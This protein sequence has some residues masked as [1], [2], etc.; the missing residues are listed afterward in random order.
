MAHRVSV[1]PGDGVGPEVV[2][3]AQAVLE[4]TGVDIEWDEHHLGYLSTAGEGPL[5][6][7]TLA[8]IRRNG[9]ALKGPV[10]T[11]TT[12][13]PSANVALRRALDLYV[14]VRPARSLGHRPPG[15]AGALD[16]VVVRET[17]ED[18][19][20]G[21]EVVAGT[22]EAEELR[23]WLHDRGLGDV[24]AGSAFSLKP[25]S[26]AAV[27][28]AA[29]FTLEW[30]RRNGRRKL[31]VVHKSTVMRA[32][33]GIYLDVLDELAAAHPDVVVDRCQVDAACARLV[34]E[35]EAFDVLFM[36]NMYGDIMSDIAAALAGGIGSAPGANFGDGVAV[37]EAV[38]GTAPAH[39]GRDDVNPL[40]LI[41][42]GVLLL[43]H[44]GEVEAASR[45][46]AAVADLVRSGACLTYDLLGRREGAARTSEVAAA[47]VD[48][49]SP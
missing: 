18:L 42:S 30:M 43:A 11:S 27:Q 9:V 13:G 23:G 12:G 45:L 1:V 29:A 21:I 47:L 33:D 2:R 15:A 14:Q 35:P 40:G 16:V 37:F 4:A 8:S 34:Q 32:T 25:A 19:Y 5:P 17:T 41:R 46:D 36:P 3:A 20:Q 28:R 38:H 39:A 10:A 44:L 6:E 49:L 24:A 31:T 26:A 7:A 48:R 22:A